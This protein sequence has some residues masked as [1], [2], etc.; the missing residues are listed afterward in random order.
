MGFVGTGSINQTKPSQSHVCLFVLIRINHLAELLF[1]SNWQ[2]LLSPKSW[3]TITIVAA[4]GQG[5]MIT[6][7]Q[8]NTTTTLELVLYAYF[9]DHN[10]SMAGITV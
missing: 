10:C 6:E 3:H 9:I 1:I 2:Y 7:Q 8:L 5:E 4:F